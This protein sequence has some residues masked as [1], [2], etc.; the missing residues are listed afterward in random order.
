MSVSI[1]NSKNM[2]KSDIASAVVCSINLIEQEQKFKKV[3]ARSLP[4]VNSIIAIIFT[5]PLSPFC[6]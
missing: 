2:V 5:E 1:F 6:Q 4:D 3:S